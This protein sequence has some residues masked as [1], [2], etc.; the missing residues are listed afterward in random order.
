MV[1]DICKKTRQMTENMTHNKA[2]EGDLL[3]IMDAMKN[4]GYN[5]LD[6]DEHGNTAL[7]CAALGGQVPVVKFF[8]EDL[9]YGPTLCSQDGRTVLHVASSG[10]CLELVRYLLVEQKLEALSADVRGH[11]PLNYACGLN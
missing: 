5:P 1:S 9:N 10:D 11:T 2:C 7:H 3:G 8:L 4:E 6:R